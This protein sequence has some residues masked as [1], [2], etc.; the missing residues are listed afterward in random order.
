MLIEYYG[1]IKKLQYSIII[2]VVIVGSIVILQLSH[3]EL[4]GKFRRNRLKYHETTRSGIRISSVRCSEESGFFSSLGP[5]CKFSNICVRGS[6]VFL[7]LQDNINVRPWLGV[8]PSVPSSLEDMEG[9]FNMRS[10]TYQRSQFLDGPPRPIGLVA[11]VGGDRRRNFTFQPEIIS[12]SQ[13]TSNYTVDYRDELLIPVS[14][15]AAGNAGH[16][17]WETLAPALGLASYFGHSFSPGDRPLRLLVLNHCDEPND[18]D[19][20][21][22]YPV[23]SCYRYVEGFLSLLSDKPPIFLS[24]R[25]YIKNERP[26]CFSQGISGYGPFHSFIAGQTVM[27][28]IGNRALRD[29]LYFRLGLKTVRV[30]RKSLHITVQIKRVGRHG[31]IMDNREEVESFIKANFVSYKKFHIQVTILNLEITTITDQ[32]RMLASTDIYFSSGGTGLYMSSLLPDDTIVIGIPKCEHGCGFNEIHQIQTLSNV[33]LLP[34]PLSDS[35]L[36]IIDRNHYKLPILYLNETLCIAI[37]QALTV[38]D[39]VF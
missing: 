16:M 6:S 38:R 39:I 13:F 26:L 2:A 4:I 23:V 20:L 24:K 18:W 33:H 37:E 14:L 15:Y 10:F 7:T 21:F 3:S 31:G 9:Q 29:A 25:P 30:K 32:I 19:I 1:S 11:R 34:F 36:D 5:S 27:S 17:L 12:F 35:D 28:S 22:G 8:K